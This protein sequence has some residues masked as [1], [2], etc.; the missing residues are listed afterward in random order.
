MK[1]QYM[2]GPGEFYKIRNY[3]NFIAEKQKVGSDANNQD[4]PEL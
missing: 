2:I 1:N 4:N 3:F